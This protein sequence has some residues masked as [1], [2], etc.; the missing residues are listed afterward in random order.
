MAEQVSG[1]PTRKV[2]VG[3]LA[4]ALSTVVVW[5]LNSYI[6]PPDKPITAEIALA[7]TTIIS[8]IAMYFVAPAPS[9]QVKPSQYR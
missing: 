3:G 4:N 2:M 7:L 6:L 1:G 9:D 8:F 5:T